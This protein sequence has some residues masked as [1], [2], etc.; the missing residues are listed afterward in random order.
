V[1]KSEKRSVFE[2]LLVDD[3]KALERLLPL[4]ES[5]IGI[6]RSTGKAVILAPIS[7][8]YDRERLFLQLLGRYFAFELGLRKEP[9]AD[10]AELSQDTGLSPKAIS[11]RISELKP[12]KVIETTAIGKYRIVPINAESYVR[13]IISTIEHRR[14]SD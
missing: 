3:K 14:R 8:L 5:L 7:K 10:I 4:I 12:M 9:F 13:D 1:S 2:K 6:E 11:A